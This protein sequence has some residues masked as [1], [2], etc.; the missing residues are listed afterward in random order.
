MSSHARATRRS[1]NPQEIRDT[2]SPPRKLGFPPCSP[3]DP[4]GASPARP[5]LHRTEAQKPAH[6]GLGLGVRLWSAYA[7]AAAP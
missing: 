3:D 2:F 6:G 7:V 1:K 4:R 5:V